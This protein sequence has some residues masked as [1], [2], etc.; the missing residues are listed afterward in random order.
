MRNRN[1]KPKFVWA[2]S[3][4]PIDEISDLGAAWLHASQALVKVKEFIPKDESAPVLI[5]N[6]IVTGKLRVFTD[7]LA[8]KEPEP[9]D[10]FADGSDAVPNDRS[11]QVIRRSKEEAPRRL[12]A[13]LA[14]A[15]SGFRTWKE[16]WPPIP[17]ELSVTHSWLGRQ[18]N[19]WR[20]SGLIS[21]PG[22]PSE[23]TQIP[24][25]NQKLKWNG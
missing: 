9:D 3:R 13:I 20:R 15:D 22:W 4:K 19:D 10:L 17:A 25:D 11:T 16:C 21:A 18:I 24:P 8:I 12:Q 23:R 14:K 5:A 6:A 1:P 7:Y 2:T